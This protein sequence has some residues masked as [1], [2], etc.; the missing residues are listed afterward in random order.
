MS[1]F[2]NLSKLFLQVESNWTLLFLDV[3]RDQIGLQLDII[4]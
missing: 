2:S 1:M 4:V 3:D